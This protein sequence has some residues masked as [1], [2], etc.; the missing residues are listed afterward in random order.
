[1]RKIICGRTECSYR[2]N[3]NCKCTLKTIALDENGRCVTYQKLNTTV[4]PMSAAERDFYEH[5]NMC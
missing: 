3:S 4:R 2:N 5:T 1:M